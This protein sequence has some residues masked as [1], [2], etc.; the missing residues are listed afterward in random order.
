[1]HLLSLAAVVSLVSMT[2]QMVRVWWFPDW[3]D[4]EQAV[5]HAVTIMMAEFFL[6][7]AGFI[8]LAMSV[9][10]EKEHR[11]A[12][13]ALILVYSVGCG[14]LVL[15]LARGESSIFVLSYAFVVLMRSLN[16]FMTPPR[17]PGAN[18]A[19][20]SVAGGL[21]YLAAVF[22][23]ISIPFPSG[24]I[25]HGHATGHGWWDRHP[26]QVIGAATLF[27]LGLTCVEAFLWYRSCR[28]KAAPKK[29]R[30]G[31]TPRPFLGVL[32]ALLL[33]AALLALYFLVFPDFFFMLLLFAAIF[34][35]VCSRTNT[36]AVSLLLSVVCILLRGA[37][38]F[39]FGF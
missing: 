20:R 12:A 11:F 37:K 32:S 26:E 38:V 36:G 30:D 25:V 5:R 21:L 29:A 33:I 9:M 28:E 10:Q 16:A 23:T 4:Q 31:M 17:G 19:V 13:L 7:H 14:S 35:G 3:V 39:I 18:A 27:F 24:A 6:V 2:V 34:T 15:F 22:A 8:A 1:M